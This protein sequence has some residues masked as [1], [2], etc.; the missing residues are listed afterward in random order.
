M[1]FSIDPGKHQVAMAS[2]SATGNLINAESIRLPEAQKVRADHWAILGDLT[3][4]KIISLCV[5]YEKL[6]IITEVPEVHQRGSGKG[7]PND[8]IDLAGVVGAI[9][10]AIRAR[11]ESSEVVWSPLP[12]EWKGQLPKTVTQQRVNKEKKKKKKSRIQWSGEKHNIY[13]AIH[14][15]LVYLHRKSLRFPASC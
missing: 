1:F 7:D 3:A 5:I 14:L 2:W 4:K 6:N 9:V 8:L 12:K 15:G 10:G 11:R 13:D